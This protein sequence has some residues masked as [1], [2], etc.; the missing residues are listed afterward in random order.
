[1]DMK[2]QEREGR[3]VEIKFSSVSLCKRHIAIKR[4]L[5]RDAI[6]LEELNS[7]EKVSRNRS[8]HRKR[9]IGDCFVFSEP[10]DIHSIRLLRVINLHVLSRIHP[11]REHDTNDEIHTKSRDRRSCWW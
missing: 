11:T 8:A 5:L 6:T 4:S 2:R 10:L 7:H 1:M 9:L 3:G